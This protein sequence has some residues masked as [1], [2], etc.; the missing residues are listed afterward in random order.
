MKDPIAFLLI[1]MG[2]GAFFALLAAGIVV[3]Y[4]G[5]GVINFAHGAIAMYT[6]FQFN[7]LRRRGVLHLPWVDFLPTKSINLP[8]KIEIS[9]GGRSSFIVAFVLAMATAVL[10]GA[11]AHFLVFRPLRNA[12]ALGKVI[13]SLGLMLF[14]QG[15]ALKNFGTENPQPET[16]LPKG[17]YQ[18]FLGLG[19][20]L[21][22]EAFFLAVVAVAVGAALWL[23]YRYTRFGLAT[24]AAAGNE[25][26]ATLLGYSPERLALV[27]WILSAVL[28][29]LA[30]VLVGNI[31]G[32]LVVTKFT[33][34]VVPALGAALIG[35]LASVPLAV[36]GGL[37]LGMLD[38]FT[39]TWL[40]GQD[41]FPSWLS[42]GAKDALPLIVIAVVL[43]SRGK[44]LPIRGTVEEKRLPL[45]PYPK[46]IVPHLVIWG[47]VLV[48]LAYILEGQ[49]GY[50]L[51]TSLIAS[52]LM[53]GFV[54]LTGYVGQISMAQLSIA[55]VA[56]FFM[57]RM[58]ANG[59]VSNTQP[60]PVSGPDLPWPI[61]A[62]LGI[63]VAVVVGVLLGLPALRVR[64]VQLAV[65]TI[66][67][68]VALQTLYFENDKLT[69]LRAGS[70]AS[71][72][73][74]FFFGL[75]IGSTSDR[76]L[77]DNPKFALFCIVVLG[78]LAVAV[79]NLRRSGTGRR[80]LAV[81]A[82]ERAAA[83]SGIHVPRTKMLAFAVSSAIAGVAG[84][85]TAFQQGQI[86]S[87]SWVFFAGLAFLAFA[88]LGGITS[89]NGAMIGGLLAPTGLITVMGS[90]HTPGLID[91]TAIMGGAGMIFTAIR[92]PAGLAPTF[93]PLI[94][95]LGRWLKT[96]RG[97]EWIAGAKRVLPGALL[98]M[99][100]VSY[101]LY[102]KAEEF[103]NW[104][105]LM[106]I[107]YGLA[108]RA[109][110]LELYHGIKNA[111]QG[112]RRTPP[113]TVP[114]TALAGAAGGTIPASSG[115]AHDGSGANST[116]TREDTTTA[117][118]V[119]R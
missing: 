80:F 47:A 89:V 48:A 36:A 58:M 38:S 99:A 101:M 56:A 57:A 88:Y 39:S 71:V 63:A 52:M 4:K 55:G 41:W 23:M 103:R 62:F 9:S 25:K 98:G 61:A 7:S 54:V 112:K 31:T 78:L 19:K 45:S 3:A 65:V 40:R 34:L 113:A 35:G 69:D 16:V 50:G 51:T 115:R 44:S 73:D 21:S 119:Q 67:A 97:P 104:H 82:N 92:Q 6:A 2:A 64:G 46:R 43:F 18:N 37:G 87:A 74:P 91:Y 75:D 106:V 90:H 95:Y 72:K 5:S 33:S 109:I 118:G 24:R 96:A 20:P 108:I 77:T 94:Q 27:N 12:A 68:A 28:A 49:W 66:A 42:S 15:V 14:L 93:Q 26:G 79:C 102:I 117:T 111:V 107:V 100:F 32:A 22:K 10:L 59:E 17:L 105:I 30:G 81:R 76:G 11:L 53:L 8:V 13:G 116:P 29:G 86:S 84:V 110:V 114:V 85:M 70:N 1:G 60:F 83:A